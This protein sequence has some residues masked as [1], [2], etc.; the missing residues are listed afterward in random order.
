MVKNIGKFDGG[1]FDNAGIKN[2]GWDLLIQTED[3]IDFMLWLIMEGNHWLRMN[4]HDDGKVYTA[5]YP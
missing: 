5:N 4:P 2:H 3:L 1:D